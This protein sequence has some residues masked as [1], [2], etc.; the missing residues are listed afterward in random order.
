M[1]NESCPV[2]GWLGMWRRFV[3]DAKGFVR[4]WPLQFKGC[5]LRCG[6]PGFDLIRLREDFHYFGVGAATTATF[7]EIAP[8][9]TSVRLLVCLQV[10][11][12][13]GFVRFMINEL[14]ARYGKS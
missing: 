6:E 9:H 4:Q 5:L 3:D 12:S 13:V 14:A 7:P 8:H 2:K 1:V 11:V 10:L